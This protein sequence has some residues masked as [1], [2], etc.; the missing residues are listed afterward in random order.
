MR[1]CELLFQDRGPIV[2]SPDEV[3]ERSETLREQA[4]SAKK[5]IGKLAALFGSRR[6][7]FIAKTSSSI[8]VA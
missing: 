5:V 7:R 6:A 2:T 1:V 4:E 8:A 3:D